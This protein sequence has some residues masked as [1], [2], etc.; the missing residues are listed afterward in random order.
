MVTLFRFM[1]I[2]PV[3]LNIK[4][5]TAVNV[6]RFLVYGI[7]RIEATNFILL[8]ERERPTRY[9]CLFRIFV[10]VKR[11]IYFILRIK[12]KVKT[13]LLGHFV[14]KIDIINAEYR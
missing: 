2:Y 13:N 14:H 4:R 1:T 12:T 5:I 7:A 3:S 8:S 11:S 10:P 6:Q 9:I